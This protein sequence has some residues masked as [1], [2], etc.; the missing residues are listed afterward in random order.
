MFKLFAD[1]SV[2]NKQQ[3]ADQTAKADLHFS[4]FLVHKT[5]LS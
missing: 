5:G 4:S 1:I 3:Y 2:A